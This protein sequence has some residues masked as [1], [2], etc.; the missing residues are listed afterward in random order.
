MFRPIK[1]LLPLLLAILLAHDPAMAAGPHPGGMHVK[2]NPSA[3]SQTA[4]TTQTTQRLLGIQKLKHFGIITGEAA[5]G[6]DMLYM[7]S[8]RYP[9]MVTLQSIRWANQKP[10]DYKQTG[11]VSQIAFP[12]IPNRYLG[13]SSMTINGKPH[14]VIVNKKTGAFSVLLQYPGDRFILLL[15]DNPKM[16]ADIQDLINTSSLKNNLLYPKFKA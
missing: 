11:M 16:K 13:F 8:L 14:P 5:N 15:A 1:N 2:V 12:G 7:K 4:L 9:G 6:T 10:L 3:I